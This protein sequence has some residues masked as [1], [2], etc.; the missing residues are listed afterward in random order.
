MNDEFEFFVCATA[1]V[2]ACVCVREPT[3]RLQQLITLSVISSKEERGI[4]V[5][6]RRKRCVEWRQEGRKSAQ[7]LISQCRIAFNAFA[8]RASEFA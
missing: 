2:C 6:R 1:C 8:D 7:W 4:E 3:G 5:E